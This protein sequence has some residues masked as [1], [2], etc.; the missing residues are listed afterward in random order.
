MVTSRSGVAPNIVNN[1]GPVSP[2]S[3]K[4]S[5][6][7]TPGDGPDQVFVQELRLPSGSSDVGEE[8]SFSVAAL[9]TRYGIEAGSCTSGSAASSTWSVGGSAVASG[10]VVCI[11]TAAWDKAS[12][13]YW[14]FDSGKLL[15]F[16]T[17][18]DADYDALYDWWK[19][20]TLF[21][22]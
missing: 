17:R 6:A 16:A 5:L 22:E 14:S 3:P 20:L 10:N 11:P 8:A 4:A 7:C 19:N 2:G 12:W 13:I 18:K 9:A 15:G 1:Y 21:I